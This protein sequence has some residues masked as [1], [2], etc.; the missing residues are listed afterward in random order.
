MPDPLDFRPALD[1]SP[2][3][4][5]LRLIFADALCDRCDPRARVL[6][7]ADAITRRV[8]GV[9]FPDRSESFW[10]ESPGWDLA[11]DRLEALARQPEDSAAF[12]DRYARLI[13]GDVPLHPEHLA[14]TLR[15]QYDLQRRLLASVHLLDPEG[16]ITAVD[17]KHY[18]L[19]A[20]D[21]ILTR[22][23]SPDLHRKLTQGFDTLLLVPFGLSVERFFTAWC[24]GLRRNGLALRTV[25]Q[26]N[27]AEPLSVWGGYR[28][29]PL[30]YEPHSFTARHGAR[31]KEQLLA[32]E[33]R[34]VD[35]LLVEGALPDLPR[36]GQGRSIGGRPQ[37]ACGRS[38]RAY[39]RALPA[40][41]VGLTPEAYVMHSLDALERRGQVL[42]FQ[43]ASYLLGA[44]LPASR[45]APVAC[46]SPG[47]GRAGMGG[48]DP[49]FRLP[50]NGARAAVRVC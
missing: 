21:D 38:P 41:E 19:P 22:L 49:E 10:T 27:Q 29:Q 6:W 35:V 28:T 33:H 50:D 3:N 2:D 46:W 12:R 47:D 25:G 23:E 16:G 26:C 37:L 32:T 18:P 24:A 8:R 36:A 17:G 48:H 9:A 39:L 40:G 31:T 45:H 1:A 30:V 14:P 34:G 42:D 43:T 7:A 11:A 44:Y 5:T 4:G 20:F 15:L 13:R